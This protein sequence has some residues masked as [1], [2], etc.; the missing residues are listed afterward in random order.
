[1]MERHQ[2]FE[3]LSCLIIQKNGFAYLFMTKNVVW[4]SMSTC[5]QHSDFEE[6]GSQTKF[7]QRMKV[8]EAE[9]D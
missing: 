8:A 7:S 9:Q 1:M 3:E 2:T 5:K 6:V 4:E